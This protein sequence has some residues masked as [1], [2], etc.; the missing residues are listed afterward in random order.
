MSNFYLEFSL[1]FFG[2]IK[3]KKRRDRLQETFYG[4]IFFKTETFEKK[5]NIYEEVSY[6]RQCKEVSRKGSYVNKEEKDT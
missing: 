3:K 5:E 1:H 6:Y 4:K 2:S